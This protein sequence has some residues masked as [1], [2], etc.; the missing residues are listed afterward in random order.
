[1]TFDNIIDMQIGN[2]QVLSVNLNNQQ[3]WPL[4]DRWYG[5]KFVGSSTIGIRTGNLEYHKSLPLQSQMKGC[6]IDSSNNIKWLNPTD[7]TKY[8]DGTDID[9]ALNIMVFVPDYYIE[10]IHNEEEQSDEI[11]ISNIQFDNS[12]LVKGGYCSAYEAYNDNGVLKSKKD[13]LPTVNT[14]RANFEKYAQANGNNWHA[15]TYAMHKAIT[16][17]FVVEYANRNGQATY[18][19]ELT[20][21]GYHQGGLGLGVTNGTETVNGNTVYSFVP[22]GITDEHGNNT[23]ITNWNGKNRTYSVPRYRGIENP[24]GHVWKNTVDVIVKYNTNTSLNEVYFTDNPNNFAE[25]TVDN[26]TLTDINTPISNG[27]IKYVSNNISGDLFPQ[28]NDSITGATSNIFYCDYHYNNN[29]TSSRT[30]LIGGR[31]GNGAAAGWFALICNADVGYAVAH[32]GCRLI[33]L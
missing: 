3:L 25:T 14:T 4:Y 24:F 31:S 17:L 15:Y 23:G 16:W 8:E 9:N 21:E 20:I 33:Y 30:V 22:C 27:Y 1:M 18:N 13:V 7:W 32:V 19:S 10:F 11:R 2:K 6:T 28:N 29:S 12:V 5:V 26:F